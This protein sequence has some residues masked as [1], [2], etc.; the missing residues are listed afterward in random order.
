MSWFSLL[1]P[2]KTNSSTQDWFIMLSLSNSTGDVIRRKHTGRKD[3]VFEVELQSYDTQT[4]TVDI[5][6]LWLPKHKPGHW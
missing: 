1:T 6:N 3:I 2:D 5:Y 4:V